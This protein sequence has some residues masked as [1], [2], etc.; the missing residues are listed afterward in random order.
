MTVFYNE[1]KFSRV[2]LYI[3]R[4]K[5]HTTWGNVPVTVNVDDKFENVEE[6]QIEFE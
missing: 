3:H 2:A 4:S 5:G 6:M 1:G